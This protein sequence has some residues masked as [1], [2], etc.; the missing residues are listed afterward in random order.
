MNCHTCRVCGGKVEVVDSR[1]ID[2]DGVM[3][4]W[5][6]KRCV[7]CR[8]LYKTVEVDYEIAKEIYLD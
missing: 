5:R 1:P 8:A 2:M 4:I 3:T 6:R 7:T